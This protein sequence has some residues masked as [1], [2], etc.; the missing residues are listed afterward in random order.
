MLDRRLVSGLAVLAFLAGGVG[1]AVAQYTSAEIPALQ[2]IVNAE[3]SR[4]ATAAELKVLEDG[5]AS[6]S[7]AI[8]VAAVR[9]LG[10]LERPSVSGTIIP[11][12]NDASPAVREEAADALAQS[13]I[14]VT[15]DPEML[16]GT[17]ALEKALATEKVP[18]V[19][20]CADGVDWPV[21]LCNCGE[22]DGGGDVAGEGDCAGVEACCIGGGAVWGGDGAGELVS[23]ES[24]EVDAE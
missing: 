4:A 1:C 19:R 20:A 6:P 13:Q 11:L 2:R 10:R 9:A 5:L 7:A 22:C 3:E 21:A 15:S 16:A 14:S 12:L 17:W 18:A 8:R 24:R 23:S